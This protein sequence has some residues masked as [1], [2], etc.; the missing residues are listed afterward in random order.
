VDQ[1]S[2]DDDNSRVVLD[3][4]PKNLSEKIQALTTKIGLQPG[5]TRTT[6]I[7]RE[8]HLEKLKDIAWWDRSNLKDAMDQAFELYIASKNIEEI[9]FRKKPTD[10]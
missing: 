8:T 6:V 9:P 7:I 1:N 10:S 4:Q 5:W 3:D 2:K